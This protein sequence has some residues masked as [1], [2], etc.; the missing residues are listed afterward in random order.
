MT[1][2]RVADHDMIIL[3]WTVTEAIDQWIRE[4]ITAQRGIG[5]AFFRPQSCG[6][7]DSPRGGA[8]GVIV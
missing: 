8:N 7:P 2:L 4:K 1:D 6:E 3:I 5:V